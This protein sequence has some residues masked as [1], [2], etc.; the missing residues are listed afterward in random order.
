MNLSD[1]KQIG[2]V[3]GGASALMLC[4]EAAKLGI[5][6][7]LL[8][9]KIN[10]MG[11]QVA[12]EHIIAPITSENVKKLSLRCDRVIFNTKPDFEMDVKLHAPTYPRKETLNELCHLKNTMELLEMLEIPTP[13]TYYQDHKEEAYAQIEHLEMPF[14][15]V[16][17]Y[18]NYSKIMDVYT[19]EDLA[20]FI[21]E[22]D[23]EADQ[24]L[25]QPIIDYKQTISCICLVDPS[26]K[27]HLYDPIEITYGQ[28]NTCYLKI[29]DTL[30]K[31]MV[32][33]LARYNRKIMKELQ[34]VGAY[35]IRYGIKANKS[36]EL[37]DI[38]PELGVGSL[39]TL[40]A[41]ETS[42][43]EQYVRMVLGLKV[44]A[45]QLEAYV[46]GIIKETREMDPNEPGHLYQIDAHALCITRQVTSE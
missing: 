16:K 32:T 24:F 44:A 37:I 7:C 30:T 27:V 29:A 2:I 23:E 5:S 28:D 41:Y 4:I 15:F 8:D 20:D 40:E 34:P 12:T 17:Q 38:T 26:G 42:I 19:K 18:A 9:P 1:V 22:V 3:G 35:T 46:Q 36:V 11:A 25:I 31:T 33:R 39:L 13:K 21:L 43:F 14:K 45:P 10:A 6:T